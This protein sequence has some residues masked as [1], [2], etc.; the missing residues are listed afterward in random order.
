MTA[1]VMRTVHRGSGAE[2]YPLGAR[3][4]NQ[5]YYLT[6]ATPGRFQIEIRLFIDMPCGTAAS[7]W[8]A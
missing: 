6:P 7:L 1:I 3:L 2:Q 5:P 8:Q 4:F